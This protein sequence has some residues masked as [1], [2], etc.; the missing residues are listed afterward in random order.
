MTEEQKVDD[1]PLI[2]FLAKLKEMK[3]KVVFLNTETLFDE[4]MALC[5]QMRELKA[6]FMREHS[7][8]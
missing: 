8:F 7:E 2:Q 6:T 4:A 1:Y 3:E 5:N